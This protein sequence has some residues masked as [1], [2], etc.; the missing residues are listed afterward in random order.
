M[1]E[2]LTLGW[3]GHVLKSGSG[4]IGKMSEVGSDM[5]GALLLLHDN[6]ARRSFLE[7]LFTDNGFRLEIMTADSVE[8]ALTLARSAKPDVVVAGL[9]LPHHTPAEL[10]ALIRSHDPDLPVFLLEGAEASTHAA[11]AMAAGATDILTFSAGD[12]AKLPILAQRAIEQTRSLRQLRSLLA[13]QG[14]VSSLREIGASDGNG[15]HLATIAHDLRS[16]LT[17][18]MALLD[19]MQGGA[20]GDLTPAASHRVRRIRSVVDRLA[21]VAEQISDLALAET[22][23]LPVM[24]GSVD[25]ETTM[26]SAR[27]R[28]EPTLHASAVALEVTVPPGLPRVLGDATR[29]CQVITSL[30]TSLLKLAEGTTL[31]LI[32]THKG[33]FVEVMLREESHRGLP[34]EALPPGFAK[35]ARS[36]GQPGAMADGARDLG[37]SIARHLIRLQGGTL[38]TGSEVERGVLAVF[39]L[40]CETEHLRPRAERTH[41]L[42]PQP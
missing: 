38:L 17:G 37:L 5:G 3:R 39:T 27:H 2:P 36:G 32:A 33:G 21:L 6:P 29:V 13:E 1:R 26:L 18:L 42:R 16:P 10:I 8:D 19:L 31:E 4:G 9:P 22:G 12:L 30:V 23:R 40:P 41:E 35:E 24:T 28:L 15:R 11:E 20:D 34:V 14:A 25:I 7:K